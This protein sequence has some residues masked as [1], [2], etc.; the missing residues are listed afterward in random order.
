[1]TSLIQII[2]IEVNVILLGGSR[3]LS[4]DHTVFGKHPHVKNRNV[5]L[6]DQ[7]QELRSFLLAD[8]EHDFHRQI[9][10]QFEKVVF[11]QDAVLTKTGN[12]AEGR[13]TVYA[14]FSGPFEQPFIKQNT[15]MT[16]ML[17]DIEF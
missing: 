10:R 8:H 13:S 1:M 7:L 14:Q 3:L 16:T 2:R 9:T 12:G 6:L 17:V 5:L 4:V 11:V 15:T